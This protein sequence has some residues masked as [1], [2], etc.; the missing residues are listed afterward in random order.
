M[1]YGV[2]QFKNMLAERLR[3]LIKLD[4][5]QFSFNPGRSTADAS[6]VMRQLQE[7]FS[8]KK[9]K[10]HYVFMNPEKAFNR[11]PR[12]TI[13]WALIRQKIPERLV[14]AVCGIYMWNYMWN[15]D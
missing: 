12:R 9:Q 1:G 7:K 4:C 5:R 14:D 2:K 13:K 11:I 3:K 6:F 8:E 15:Q 10:L